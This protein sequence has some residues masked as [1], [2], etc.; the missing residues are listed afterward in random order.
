M[1]NKPLLIGI[2]IV[3]ALAKFILVPWLDWVTLKTQTINQL[4]LNEKRLSNVQ[5]RSTVLIA[6]EKAIDD[7]YAQLEQAWF[8]APE[9][10]LAIKVL[11][12]IEAEAKAVGVELTTR[13]TGQVNNKGATTL[14]ASVFVKGKPQDIYR[15]IAALE[16]GKPRSLF[17]SIRLIKSNRVASDM[18]GILEIL[19]P[20]KPEVANED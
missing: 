2:V 12:H 9:S 11:K 18:T 5:Q 4:S 13:N 14:P 17:A 1:K 19:V 6:Q 8:S 3:L 7:N 20:L 15:L 10:Q 16:T